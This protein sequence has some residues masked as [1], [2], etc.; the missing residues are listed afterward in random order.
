MTSQAPDPGY[1]APR[2]T[3]GAQQY[4][5]GPGS[6]YTSSDLT[7]HNARDSQPT[8]GAVVASPSIGGFMYANG[9]AFDDP[10]SKAVYGAIQNGMN[11]RT[12]QSAPM[13]QMTQM[14]LSSLYGGAQAAPAMM[15]SGAQLGTAQDQQLAAAQAKQANLLAA[16]A[17]GQ[18][19]SVAEQQARQQAAQ[20]TAAQMAALGSQR[21]ASNPAL[22]QRQAATQGAAAQQQM[23][24]TAALGRSQEAMAAQQQL[25][26]ALGGLRGQSQTTSQTQAQLAQQAGLANQSTAAQYALANQQ[27]MQQAQLAN[28]SGINQFALQQGTMNQ[29]TSM[30]NLQ[31]QTAQNQLNDQ[32]YAA[33]LQA[34]MGQNQQDIANQIA[35]QQ[36]FGQEQMSLAST[37]MGQAINSQ[38][39][40]MGMTGAAMQAVGTG[41]AVGAGLFSDRRLKTEI[42]SGERDVRSFLSALIGGSDAR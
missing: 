28:Q 33:Y 40:A 16:Q 30:A 27:A 4:G 2:L 18:G 6:W 10:N 15:T 5:S 23:A 20:I 19:P 41:V 36:L 39:N 22:A 21:G 35:Y 14:G 26:G 17:T 8:S 31:S 12:D 32:E 9:Q 24:Q 11:T 37:D 3:N 29:A 13:A 34:M 25:T 1:V 38:N 7:A 42:R